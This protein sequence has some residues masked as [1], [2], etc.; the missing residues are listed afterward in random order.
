MI[1]YPQNSINLLKTADLTLCLQPPGSSAFY[2]TMVEHRHS[3][4]ERLM[5]YVGH[6]QKTRRVSI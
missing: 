2:R 5:Y 6:R 4:E 1:N 3:L